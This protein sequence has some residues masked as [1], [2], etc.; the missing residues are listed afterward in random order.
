MS[1]HSDD[2]EFNDSLINATD[3]IN[4]KSGDSYAYP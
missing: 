4:E 2:L 1:Q 3:D